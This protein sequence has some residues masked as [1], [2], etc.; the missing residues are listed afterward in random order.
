MAKKIT[1]RPHYSIGQRVRILDAFLTEATVEAIEDGTVAL[2]RANED[3]IQLFKLDDIEPL[4]GTVELLREKN[5]A[6]TECEESIADLEARLKNLRERVP[7]LRSDRGVL[8][9]RLLRETAKANGFEHYVATVDTGVFWQGVDAPKPAPV[10]AMPRAIG[11]IPGFGVVQY[12]RD[13]ANQW[14][15]ITTTDGRVWTRRL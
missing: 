5:E 7:V 11:N 13:V 6:I 8:Q 12:D 15:S 14:E 10:P 9:Q 3:G 1:P 2:T 4:P